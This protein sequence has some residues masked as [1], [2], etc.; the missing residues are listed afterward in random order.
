MKVTLVVVD[1]PHAGKKYEFDRHDTF[2]VGRSPNAQ[3]RL[4]QDDEF[5]SRNHFLIE[6]NPPLCRLLDLSSR[7]GTFVNGNRVTSIDLQNGDKIRGGR[8]TI[9]VEF[10]RPLIPLQAVSNPGA[11]VA[12]IVP[13]G[14]VRP[15]PRSQPSDQPTIMPREGDS[16]QPVNPVTAAQPKYAKPDSSPFK[17]P[18][19]TS[20]LPQ[21][22]G[23][24]TIRT[25][26]HGAMGVVYEADSLVDRSRVAIKVVSPNVAAT[27]EDLSR[28]IR[29]AS[30]LKDLVHPNIVRYR[31]LNQR[32]GELYIVMDYIDGKT[33]ETL[34]AESAEPMSVT[35][36]VGLTQQLLDALSYAHQRGY[37]HRDVKPAN[38][39]IEMRDGV[40][41]LSLT[42]FGLAKTY[43]SSKLSG[44]TMTGEIGG[45]T[46]FMPP[47]QITN[48]RK[49]EPAA[50]QY[51]AAAT[52]YYLLTKQHI[53]NFPREPAQQ[54]LMILQDPPISIDKRRPGL[55]GDLVEIVH[56]ALSRDPSQRF[57][58]VLAFQKALGRLNLEHIGIR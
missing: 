20:S 22:P 44:L 43:Q 23:Y 29:E 32:D 53:Y 38:V 34:I 49:V 15:G 41:R 6:V 27:P 4:S 56:T 46:P 28:F 55:P 8:T 58:S 31:D 17:R 3:F 19:S 5:F 51:S 7:N 57:T 10:E 2:I 39:M 21:F 1:G 47:E 25:L 30:I 9:S 36:A 16:R 37:V 52:L 40:E 33:A 18:A 50:D 26:G 24:R 11:G 35:R 54:L 13:R 48:Y 45:T 42:D 14:Y 12:T